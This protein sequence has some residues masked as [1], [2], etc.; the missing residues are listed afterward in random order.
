MTCR[1]ARWKV[2][3]QTLMDKVELQF[4]VSPW[5]LMTSAYVPNRVKMTITKP[6]SRHFKGI[7]GDSGKRLAKAGAI[8]YFEPKLAD[9]L[10]KKGVAKL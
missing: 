3:W 1:K 7:L 4:M 6:D 9:K 2:Y 10:I 5:F 8:F